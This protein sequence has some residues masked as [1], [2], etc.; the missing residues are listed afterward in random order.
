LAI[1]NC[2]F[3]VL[4]MASRSMMIPE[5]FLY[6]HNGNPNSWVP[7]C[8]LLIQCEIVTYCYKFKVHKS[9]NLVG[10]KFTPWLH[11]HRIDQWLKS[12]YPIHYTLSHRNWGG[13]A[14]QWIQT[15]STEMCVC[16]C[17][18]MCTYTHIYTQKCAKTHDGLL[19]NRRE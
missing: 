16:M 10:Q 18:C 12:C 6:M 11:H 5:T 8:F 19:L 13:V 17:A 15:D 7:S 14:N 2:S 4:F 1:I 3:T 9:C